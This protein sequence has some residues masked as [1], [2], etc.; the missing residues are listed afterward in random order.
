[1]RVI[2]TEALE[3]EAALP[4]ELEFNIASVPEPPFDTKLVPTVMTLAAVMV[5][6]V[7]APRVIVLKVLVWA[8]FN[9]PALF[10]TGPV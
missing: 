10:V 8:R 7:L 2:V 4:A 6:V 5:V 9:V 1:M 3:S